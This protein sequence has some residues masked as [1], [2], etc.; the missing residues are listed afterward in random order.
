M[1]EVC[2][3]LE[4]GTLDLVRGRLA[5][6]RRGAPIILTS[7]EV[8]GALSDVDLV[9]AVSRVEAAKVKVQIPVEDA[10]R[11][12]AVH[13]PDELLVDAGRLRRHHAVDPVRVEERLV[14]LRRLV[15][16]LPVHGQ[17]VAPLQRD[18]PAGA[19]LLVADGHG[20]AHLAGHARAADDGLVQPQSLDH[21]CDGADVCILVVGVVSRDVVGARKGPTVRRKIEGVHCASSLHLGSIHDSMVL[22][23]V[24]A[25]RVAED[26]LLWTVPTRLVEDLGPAPAWAVE[27]D[28]FPSDVILFRHVLVGLL[29]GPV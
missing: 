23:R 10:V 22:A 25:G 17:E 29:N 27:V 11:L 20:D 28:V 19:D 21:G 18:R 6:L 16:E 7:E 12:A 4:S 1:A 8:D 15:L 14:D 2:H 13:V 9:D 3:L 5:H 24:C 26:N